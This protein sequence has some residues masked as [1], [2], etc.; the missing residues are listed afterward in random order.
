MEVMTPIEKVF[1]EIGDLKLKAPAR[2]Q[3]V[4][5]GLKGPMHTELINRQYGTVRS[6]NPVLYNIHALP[7]SYKPWDVF[8]RPNRVLAQARLV[9]ACFV[10]PKYRWQ[11]H[12]NSSRSRTRSDPL[13]RD[14][15]TH[16]K[17]RMLYRRTPNLPTH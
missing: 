12:R 6:L 15:R 14:R 2:H 1:L 7:V 17:D 4:R 11:V 13:E 10:E 16:E 5:V 8:R 3:L 9:V